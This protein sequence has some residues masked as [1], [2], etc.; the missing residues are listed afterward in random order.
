MDNK[1]N[2]SNNQLIN[3][4]LDISN[5][6]RDCFV[7]NLKDISCKAYKINKSKD[8]YYIELF[9]TSNKT[10]INYIP[11]VILICLD[12]GYSYNYTIESIVYFINNYVKKLNK[13]IDYIG[14]ISNNTKN[15]WILEITKINDDIIF[16]ITNKLNELVNINTISQMS[17]I[18][19]LY[20]ANTVINNLKN[21][22][23]NNKIIVSLL[24]TDCFLNKKIDDKINKEFVNL[25]NENKN[26]Y[27]LDIIALDNLVFKDKHIDNICSNL[28]FNNAMRLYNLA[29]SLGG[30]FIYIMNSDYCDYYF[31]MYIDNS[32]D[33]INYPLILNEY[34]SELCE[35]TDN[36][37]LSSGCIYKNK[38]VY[39]VFKLCL[40]N[41]EAFS[42]RLKYSNN[43]DIVLSNGIA[44]NEI[45][46]E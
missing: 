33:L 46:N 40:I 6:N 11:K 41:I 19:L 38:P 21:E 5:L 31:N 17:L 35:I 10:E 29:I 1:T 2:I 36:G 43:I 34:K 42:L 7:Y 39:I 8:E 16:F 18:D 22:F 32:I 27:V 20:N 28:K 37:L 24:I 26:N 45:E 15:S 25:I 44:L 3:N 23:V 13:N 14:I 9:I 30:I 4:N 12:L